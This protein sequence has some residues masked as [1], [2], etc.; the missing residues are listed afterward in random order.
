MSCNAALKTVSVS[1]KNHTATKDLAETSRYIRYQERYTCEHENQ[2]KA[3][4][5]GSGA[6]AAHT[7]GPVWLLHANTT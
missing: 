6:H 2:R 4:H 5:L 3:S 1:K 7:F